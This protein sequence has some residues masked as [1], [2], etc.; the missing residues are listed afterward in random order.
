MVQ[1]PVSL[2]C[3]RDKL[4]E[5]KYPTRDIFLEDVDLI[6]TNARDY[7]GEQNTITVKAKELVEFVKDKVE[8]EGDKLKKLELKI[9]PL[10]DDNYQNKLSYILEN[11]VCEHLWNVEGCAYFQ[12]PVDRKR[13]TD[14]VSIIANPIDLKTIKKNISRKMT[15]I[16]TVLNYGHLFSM[17]VTHKLYGIKCISFELGNIIILKGINIK[18]E[19]NF[20]TI[21]VLFM[22]IL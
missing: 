4:R 5:H 15:I 14:Y 3:I 16:Q 19:I 12:A 1:N 11:I 10:L 2:Q 9:N 6:Y 18:I 20:E 22:T 21:F 17:K 8:V 7:N 13:Y